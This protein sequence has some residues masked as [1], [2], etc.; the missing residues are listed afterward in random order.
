[1]GMAGAGLFMAVLLYK[2]YAIPLG[3]VISF[4]ITRRLMRRYGSATAA[5]ITL[6]WTVPIFTP[7]VI[8][9]Q[10]FFGGTMAPWYVAL[11]ITPPDPEFSLGGVAITIAFSLFGSLMAAISAAR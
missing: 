5:W 1:M 3:V 10:S 6:A 7:L 9:S 8:P 11:L 2:L 4:I